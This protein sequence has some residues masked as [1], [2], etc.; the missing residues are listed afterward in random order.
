MLE[1]Q[2]KG[3]LAEFLNAEIVLLTV[4]NV[5][6]AMSWLKSTFLYIRVSKKRCRAVMARS[7]QL[8]CHPFFRSFAAEWH[9]LPVSICRTA[10]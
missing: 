10:E 7:Q 6:M 8:M 5:A 2:L 1:S 4:G 3:Q 9:S